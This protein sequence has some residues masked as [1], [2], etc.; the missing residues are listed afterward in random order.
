MT[1]PKILSTL[2]LGNVFLGVMLVSIVFGWC[3]H[4]VFEM[5]KTNSVLLTLE[6]LHLRM[7][8]FSMKTKPSLLCG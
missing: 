1:S 5:K 7:F 6:L 4:I 3:S 8:T 2:T